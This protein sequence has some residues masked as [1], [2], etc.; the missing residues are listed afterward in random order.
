LS[1][2]CSGALLQLAWHT[3]RTCLQAA[4]AAHLRVPPWSCTAMLEVLGAAG[5]LVSHQTCNEAL[6][7]KRGS[8]VCRCCADGLAAGQ[9]LSSML[10]AVRG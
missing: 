6:M 2:L 3:G 1:V 5:P 8:G 7:L 10:S 4:A 9:T